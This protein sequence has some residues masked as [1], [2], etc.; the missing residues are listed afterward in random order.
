MSRNDPLNYSSAGYSARNR[1]TPRFPLTTGNSTEWHTRW[2]C[3]NGG[4]GVCA[5][6][7][8]GKSHFQGT[9]IVR[10]ADRSRV[11]EDAYADGPAGA[12]I[13]GGP[14]GDGPQAALQIITAPT[15]LVEH[16]APHCF[17]SGR[18]GFFVNQLPRNS[19]PGGLRLAAVA[20]I[21]AVLDVLG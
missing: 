10:G 9:G 2:A 6:P 15:C 11:R 17:R 14:V 1:D 20:A 18:I 5:L 3:A 7:A 16:F 13:A 19:V 12:S 21:Q 4:E 8:G